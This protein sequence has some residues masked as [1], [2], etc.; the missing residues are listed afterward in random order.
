MR[1]LD[2]YDEIS[3]LIEPHLQGKLIVVAVHTYDEHNPSLTSRPHVSLVT[4]SAHY[5][6]EATMP[7]GVFDPMYP[8]V[9]GES[10]C[11]RILRDRISLNLER[12]GYRVSSNH[13]YALPDGSIEVRAQVWYFFGALQ[14]LYTER[15]PET[16]DDPSHQ[17]VWE[18]L[19]NTNL[20]RARAEALRGYLHR[21]QRA[22]PDDEALFVDAQAS[23]AKITEFL[24]TSSA[25]KDYRRWADRPS[26]IALEVRKDLLCEIEP[27][28]SRPKPPTAKM[29]D[30]ARKI[31][32]TVAGAVETY[33]MTDREEIRHFERDT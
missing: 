10:T 23:Y 33:F 17:L 25:L 24:R 28:G 22:A 30:R 18:M 27:D 12:S 26:S 16:A 20:R 7:Y 19:L 3:A 15:F 2:L 14:R 6:R 11:S 13:P 29:K 31:A 4:Q 32:R 8:D 5:Q 9:L 21:Y 1:V